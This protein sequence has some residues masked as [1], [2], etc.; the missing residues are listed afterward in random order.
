MATSSVKIRRWTR[1]EYDRLIDLGLLHEDEKVELLGGEI[2]DRRAPPRTRRWSR[3]EY[4][5][6]IDAGFFQ[7]GEKIDLLAGDLVVREPQGDPHALGI[8]RVNE[9]LRAAFGPGWR[10]R[11][12]L[13]IALD[14]ESEPEPDLSVAPGPLR[15]N[16]A[17]KPSNPSLLVEIA[18]SSLAFDREHKGSLYA[19]AQVADYWIVNLVDRVL[20][21]YRE[22]VQAPAA[23]YGWQYGALLRLG[24]TDFIS[25]L[26]APHARV[27]VAD[28]L[29]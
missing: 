27:A 9:A 19:R 10:V 17:A 15:D 11:V 25:P 16:S 26:A 6:L 13:P 12:Q 20:E 5:R 4:N 3:L 24:P 2:I 1:I 7:P 28:L 8:E 18:V 22:P 23:A 14:D 29:P 21:I